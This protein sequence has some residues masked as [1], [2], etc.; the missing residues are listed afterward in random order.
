MRISTS[1]FTDYTAAQM[2]AKQAELAR[3]Q[4][5]IASGKAISKPSDDPATVARSQNIDSTRSRIEQL[6]KNAVIANQRIALEED[7]LDRVTDMI[8]RIQEL[9]LAA[10]SG[11]VS[12][13]KLFAYGSEVQQHL[14]E[15]IDYG[16]TQN[17]NGEYIFAG[18]KGKTQPFIF[19]NNQVSYQGDQGNINL[20]IGSSRTVAVSDSGDQVFQDIPTGNGTFVVGADNANTGTGVVGTGSVVNNTVYQPHNFRIVF[21]ATDTFDVINDTTG[22]VELAG[23]SYRDGATFTF[24]GIALNVTGAPQAG[25]TFT[26]EPSRHE[27]LFSTLQRFIAATENNPANANERAQLDQELN[28]V[29]ENL[30][31]AHIHI[32]T[33][34]SSIGSRLRYIEAANQ[35]N[36]SLDYLLQETLSDL[37]DTDYAKAASELQL[38]MT[39]LEAV[40]QTYAQLQGNSLFNYL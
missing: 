37:T 11:T 20:Q 27:D 3:L 36:G 19:D 38:Q 9:G 25:D 33:T 5:Q 23:E 18:K 30:E 4:E 8:Q 28:T 24:N 16:N 1:Y 21:T 14:Y 40:R 26:V 35:E 39:T 10:K 6:E 12:A 31:Q 29:L 7:T 17:A 15:L 13:E 22:A 2:N 34:R 32:N